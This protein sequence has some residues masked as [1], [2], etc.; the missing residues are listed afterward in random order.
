MSKP[1]LTRD[2]ARLAAFFE[3]EV[4]DVSF[5]LRVPAAVELMAAGVLPPAVTDQSI[6]E[7]KR[8]EMWRERARE[9]GEKLAAGDATTSLALLGV[10]MVEPRLW[11]GEEERCPEEWVTPAALGPYMDELLGQCAGHIGYGETRRKALDFRP[12]EGARAVAPADGASD[13]GEPAPAA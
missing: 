4:G 2:A 5:K 6:P 1:R 10:M 9:V 7:A 11:R 12:E 13:R 8:M 3:V